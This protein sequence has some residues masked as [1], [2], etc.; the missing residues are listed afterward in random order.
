MALSCPI[1]SND[2]SGADFEA[3]NRSFFDHGM[4]LLMAVAAAYEAPAR[5]PPPSSSDDPAD[6]EKPTW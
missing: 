2:D 5:T 1:G 3:G 6:G 4:N